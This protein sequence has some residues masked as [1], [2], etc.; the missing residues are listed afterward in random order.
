M[1]PPPLVTRTSADSTGLGEG[2]RALRD[3]CFFSKATSMGL[4]F[5][6]C[7]V[8]ELLRSAL[9]QSSRSLKFCGVRKLAATDRSPVEGQYRHLVNVL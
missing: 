4:R 5:F 2:S 1:H 3:Y 7:A 6:T 8:L 9:V